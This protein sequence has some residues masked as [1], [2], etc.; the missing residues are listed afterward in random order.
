MRIK[1][2]PLAFIGFTLLWF[3]SV[4]AQTIVQRIDT[5]NEGVFS[6][7]SNGQTNN[8][9]S[10]T[11][12]SSD[13]FDTRENQLNVFN[14]AGTITA[15]L[16]ANVSASLNA[17]VQDNSITSWNRNHDFATR[18]LTVGGANGLLVRLEEEMVGERVFVNATSVDGFGNGIGAVTFVT[19]DGSL[20]YYVPFS[21]LGAIDFTQI[22][23]VGFSLRND[24]PT[25]GDFVAT[26]FYTATTVPEPTNAFLLGAIGLGAFVRRRRR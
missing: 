5:F 9:D 8:I 3:S 15:D 20:D 26:G 7:S 12:S 6:L 19:T 17:T 4:D 25:T 23:V 21:Q 16:D 24:S 13:F 11:S 14:Q 22:E 10:I 2:L 1:T 18:D